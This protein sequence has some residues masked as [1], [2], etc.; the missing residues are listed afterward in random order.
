VKREELDPVLMIEG[1]QSLFP[2]ARHDQA[3]FCPYCGL[4]Y[5]KRSRPHDVWDGI[6]WFACDKG[7]HWSACGSG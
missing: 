7:H 6:V 2:E 1:Q 4:E 3:R 5:V